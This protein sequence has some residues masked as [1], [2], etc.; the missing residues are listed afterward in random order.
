M[1]LQTVLGIWG[2]WSLDLINQI[3]VNKQLGVVKSN[4]LVQVCLG[5]ISLVFW[6]LRLWKLEN[7]QDFRLDL[8]KNIR[9]QRLCVN[10]LLKAFRLMR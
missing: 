2:C 9:S 10:R 5:P 7:I 6:L 3:C 1:R 4:E 8:W